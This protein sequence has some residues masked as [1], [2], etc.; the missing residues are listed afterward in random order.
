M[1][2]LLIEAYKNNFETIYENKLWGDGESLSGTGS[3]YNYNEKY[4]KFLEEFFINKNIKSVV[5]IGCG[6]WNFS[7]HIN[8]GDIK[9]DGYD[10]VK[11][12]ID[13]NNNNYKTDKIN[14]HYYKDNNFIF[15]KAD[16][17][18][19]KDVLQHLSFNTMSNIINQLSKYKYCLITND[20]DSDTINTDIVDAEHRALDIRKEPLNLKGD[21]VFMFD[22]TP[23]QWTQKNTILLDNENG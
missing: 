6:D 5:E 18:I 13:S 4:I 7:K 11:S 12:V 21:I 1:Y 16:L 14:F 19:C 17:L 2:K 10:I 8:F 23:I 22:I 9:Y 3:Y 20:F 15:P